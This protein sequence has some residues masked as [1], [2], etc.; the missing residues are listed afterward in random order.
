MF[1]KIKEVKSLDDY[2]LEVI[3]EDNTRKYYDVTPLF[4]KWDVFNNLKNIDGLFKQVKV[5]IGGYGIFWNEEIDL[6]CNE[7]WENGKHS[8]L[9]LKK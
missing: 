3:F 1:H 8:L 9:L 6:S 5:D 7:L 4:T 2:I